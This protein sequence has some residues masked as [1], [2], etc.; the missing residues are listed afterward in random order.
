MCLKQFSIR[1]ALVSFPSAA[2][3]FNSPQV[4]NSPLFSKRSTT[5]QLRHILSFFFCL[6]LWCVYV[7]LVRRW[8]LIK[9]RYLCF[10]MPKTTECP[11][12]A[13]NGRRHVAAFLFL[14]ISIHPRLSRIE[15][16]FADNLAERF[17]LPARHA[18]PPLA[19]PLPPPPV[20]TPFEIFHFPD[21]AKM[22]MALIEA[23][24]VLIPRSRAEQRRD[25]MSGRRIKLKAGK[26]L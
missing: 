22:A 19:L 16:K 15:G 8:N 6:L 4:S 9:S 7:H 10:F 21:R 11:L 25:E 2:R 1:H 12:S 3:L 24:K 17:T 13:Q 5:H 23:R 20:T 18:H 26:N 14:V